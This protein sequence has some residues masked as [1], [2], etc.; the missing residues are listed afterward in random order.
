MI[1]HTIGVGL[2]GQTA[3]MAPASPVSGYTGSSIGGYSGASSGSASNGKPGLFLLA[4]AV[5]ALAG[6]GYWTK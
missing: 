3:G 4:L 1:R 5:I 6:F 2:G